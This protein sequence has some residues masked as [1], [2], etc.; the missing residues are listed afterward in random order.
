MRTQKHDLK[1]KIK[2]LEI[3]LYNSILKEDATEQ[4]R[5]K[6]NLDVLKS[7]LINIQ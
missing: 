4:I 5:I 2:K 1:S 6:E 7:T 3:D